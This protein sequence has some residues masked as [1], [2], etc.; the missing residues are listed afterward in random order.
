MA[1]SSVL[2]LDAATGDVVWQFQG[3]GFYPTALTVADGVVYAGPGLHALDAATGDLL[4]QFQS[5]VGVP[6][7]AD[8]VM[9]V[10]AYDGYLYALLVEEAQ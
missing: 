7:G 1:M 3:E 5:G 9:Y 8:G 2:A 4:L 10:E 6:V